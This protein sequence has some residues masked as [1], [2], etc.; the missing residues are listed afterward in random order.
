MDNILHRDTVNNIAN[1]ML[2][3]YCLLQL[4][5]DFVDQECDC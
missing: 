4:L 2:M 5:R 1:G 3:G